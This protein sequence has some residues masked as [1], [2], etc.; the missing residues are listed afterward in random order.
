MKDWI[1]TQLSKME[2]DTV[3]FKIYLTTIYKKNSSN[4]NSIFYSSHYY[5]M[6][7]FCHT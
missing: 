3:L 6:Y 7:I 4:K 1:Y 2:H 5:I